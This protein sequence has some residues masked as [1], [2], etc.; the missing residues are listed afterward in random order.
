MVTPLPLNLKLQTNDSPLYSNP[1]LYR[2]FIG[3]LNFLTN[4]RPDPSFSIQ[5][6]SQFMQNPTQNH[7]KALTHTLNYVVATSGK[8]ILLKDSDSLKLQ[9]YFDSDWGA[10]LDTQRFVTGC[11]ILFGNSPINWKSKKQC[12]V[13][14]SSSEAKYRAMAASNS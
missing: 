5:A 9:A 12:T 7:F 13:S 14:K 8:G 11:V 6:L 4:T 1:A 3:K 2:S 10:C